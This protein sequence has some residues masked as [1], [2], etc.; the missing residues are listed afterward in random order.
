MLYS[1]AIATFPWVF[2]DRRTDQLPEHDACGCRPY[3]PLG[4]TFTKKETL[5]RQPGASLEKGGLVI[6]PS[7]GSLH[8]PATHLT[9]A[10]I[11]SCPR[12]TWEPGCGM[13]DRCAGEG[14]HL[15]RTA[16][17]PAARSHAD[18]RPIEQPPL[19]L[20]SHPPTHS[21]TRSDPCMHVCQ[22][23]VDSRGG[24]PR[25]CCCQIL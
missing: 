1:K 25:V 8:R 16:I 3:L 20:L 15:P 19:P 9:L 14:E 24:S 2:V 23:A 11:V 7:R 10:T 6:W 22:M 21:S 18:G 12:Q 13:E 17:R 4:E 5:C